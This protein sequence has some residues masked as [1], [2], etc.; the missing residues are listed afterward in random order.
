MKLSEKPFSEIARKSAASP[1]DAS[2]SRGKTLPTQRF[3]AS[4]I[5]DFFG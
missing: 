1:P 4:S 5:Y 3:D 2:A